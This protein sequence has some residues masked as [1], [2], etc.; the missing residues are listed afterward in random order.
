MVGVCDSSGA[1]YCTT[2][3][4]TQKL[5]DHKRS[6]NPVTTLQTGSEMVHYPDA[7]EMALYAPAYDVILEAVCQS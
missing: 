3:I 6:G 7:K 5:L 1:V 2:G 4:D